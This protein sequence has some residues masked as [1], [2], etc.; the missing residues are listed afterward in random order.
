MS[1]SGV[2]IPY[3]PHSPLVAGG[4]GLWQRL[5]VWWRTPE[6][7]AELAA[8]LNPEG[9]R[10]LSLRAHKL[11][12]TKQRARLAQTL[13][14]MVASADAHRVM[15][16]PGFRRLR[17][18]LPVRREQVHSN[19]TVLL[20][21]AERLREDR[22]LRVQGLALAERLVTDDNSPLYSDQARLP[23][24]DAVHVA[25]G[26]LDRSSR[27]GPHGPDRVAAA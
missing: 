2:T 12:T 5:R 18:S 15:V 26:K 21:L 8:G 13:E 11:A 24:H 22:P 6:L 17:P 23:L 9:T 16:A 19:R 20:H 4:P 7:D 25:L 1:P 14:K 3:N 27:S 10:L